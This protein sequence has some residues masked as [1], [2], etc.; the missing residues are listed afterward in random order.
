MR[1]FRNGV[2]DLD[3]F[4]ILLILPLFLFA[5][6]RKHQVLVASRS[7]VQIRQKRHIQHDQRPLMYR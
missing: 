5:L 4:S 2:I 6:A 1:Y 7:T 3:A